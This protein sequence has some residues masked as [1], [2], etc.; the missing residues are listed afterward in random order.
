MLGKNR[1]KERIRKLEEE[2]AGLREELAEK[3]KKIAEL[4]Q[5]LDAVKWFVWQ[6]KEAAE[7]A[8]G[9]V[10]HKMSELQEAVK[11]LETE[12]PKQQESQND[13]KA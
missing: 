7:A 13:S 10:Q 8:L 3:E 9:T 11:K 12:E 1:D 2:A 4:T 5:K 6:R